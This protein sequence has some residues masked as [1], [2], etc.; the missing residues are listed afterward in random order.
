M[1]HVAHHFDDA[2]QQYEAAGL[3]MWLFLA[4]E[5]LFFGGLFAGYAL[6]R[7]WYPLA[8]A[9]GSH[10][11]DIVLGTI[12]TAV[13]LGSSLTMALAVRAAQTDEKGPLK[14][15]LAATIVLGSAFLGV[16]AFEYKHK[17]DEHHIPGESFVFSV[18]HDANGEEN[19]ADDSASTAEKEVD[20]GNVELFFSFYFAMTGLHALH[21]VIGIVILCI[22]WW[23]AYQG[24]YS[25]ENFTPI[26]MTGLY[27]HFVDIVWVFLFPLLY[28][29]R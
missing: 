19:A 23:S 3:G 13:L 4:T 20:A 27:W 10:H 8:F 18:E 29:I 5:V 15:L 9:A 12:N 26:E 17:A 25:S 21:M 6:Y 24:R 22:L 28:L 16:K 1:Q 14:M 7:S 2:E 11:L